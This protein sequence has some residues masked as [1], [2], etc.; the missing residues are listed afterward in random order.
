MKTKKIV[1]SENV[2]FSQTSVLCQC[3]YG[4]FVYYVNISIIRNPII[5]CTYIVLREKGLFTNH[6]KKVSQNT[7]VLS[8]LIRLGVL[9]DWCV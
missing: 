8:A 9:I 3:L 4:Y 2:T 6:L 1:W 7:Y 5:R